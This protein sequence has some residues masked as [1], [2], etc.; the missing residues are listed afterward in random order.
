MSG[1]RILPGAFRRGVAGGY[2]PSYKRNE[3][4]VRLPTRRFVIQQGGSMGIGISLLLIAVGLI[5]WLAV[6]ATV[7]GVALSTVGVI[8]LVVGLLG[9]FVSMIIFGSNRRYRDT[10]YL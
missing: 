4:W 1:V 5:L 8:L 7:T 10:D 2:V 3:S 6:S 9:L